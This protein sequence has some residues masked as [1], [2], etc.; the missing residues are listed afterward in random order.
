MTEEE[1]KNQPLWKKIYNALPIVLKNCFPENFQEK[2][3]WP[4]RNPETGLFRDN[5]C[6]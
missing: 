6:K 4:K 2:W 3:K 1:R 5:Y